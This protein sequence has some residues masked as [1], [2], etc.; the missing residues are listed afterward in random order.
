MTIRF[1][2]HESLDSSES[3]SE[4]ETFLTTKSRATQSVALKTPTTLPVAYSL[5][6]SLFSLLAVWN[7]SIMP[8][9]TT[10]RFQCA[11]VMKFKRW[12]TC[13]WTDSLEPSAIRRVASLSMHVK[14]YR[15]AFNFALNN[16][17]WLCFIILCAAFREFLASQSCVW[18][19]TVHSAQLA[20]AFSTSERWVLCRFEKKTALYGNWNMSKKG[21]KEKGRR[22]VYKLSILLMWEFQ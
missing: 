5:I 6:E 13:S 8:T 1:T 7:N 9:E 15:M 16:F 22:C 11:E 4:T 18:V 17:L 2:S 20:S 19:F 12:R 10:Y 21:R 3:I 14:L